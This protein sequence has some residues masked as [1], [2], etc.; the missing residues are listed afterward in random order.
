[1]HNET[2]YMEA[3]AGAYF[4]TIEITILYVFIPRSFVAGGPI[5]TCVH[6]SVD[7]GYFP[8]VGLDGFQGQTLTLFG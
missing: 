2:L 5:G 8:N 1:M 3:C 4:E 6:E 7:F